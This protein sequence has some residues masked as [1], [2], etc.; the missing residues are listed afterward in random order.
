MA[1]EKKTEAKKQ[2]KAFVLRDCIFGKAGEI[3]T[4]SPTE[5]ATGE[6]QGMLD[7]HPDAV[8]AKR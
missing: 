6:A 8:N 4:L 2:V 1:T 7:A 3:V 5:I